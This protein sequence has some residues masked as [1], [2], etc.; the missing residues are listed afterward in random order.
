M[1]MCACI[2]VYGFLVSFA[3]FCWPQKKAWG[4]TAIGDRVVTALVVSL[5]WPIMLPAKLLYEILF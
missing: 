5:L 2:Y 4:I 1:L 3:M